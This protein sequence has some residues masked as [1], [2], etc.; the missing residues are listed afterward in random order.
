MSKTREPR[1]VTKS[2][3]ENAALHY[4]ER[5]SA[6]AEALRRVLLRRV[7]RAARCHGDDPEDGALLV[8][9]LVE[10]Y[11]A[12]GLLD[13]RQYATA[14]SKS[15]LRR[16]KSTRAIRQHLIGK[17]IA[18]DHI[19]AAMTEI[20]GDVGDA[21]TPPDLA[22]ALAYARRRRLGPYRPAELREVHRD[23]DLAALGRAGF[24]WE[25]AREVIDG[26]PK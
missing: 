2:S 13:D 9:Q 6:S 25:I 26:A 17:G 21:D 5:F 10:R 12:A 14:K 19:D 23:R 4:L 3:L 20:S 7:D 8:S 15:L 18:Q 1:R 11:V 16:G 22:A 24:S